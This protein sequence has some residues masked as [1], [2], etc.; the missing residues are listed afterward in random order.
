MEGIGATRG[1]STYGD[2]EVAFNIYR[3]VPYIKYREILEDSVGVRTI[4]R[5]KRLVF[6]D[7]ILW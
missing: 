3:L 7:G 6:K 2:R 1:S 4:Q 5:W